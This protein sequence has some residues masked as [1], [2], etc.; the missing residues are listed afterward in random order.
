M[1]ILFENNLYI[2]NIIFICAILSGITISLFVA[3]SYGIAKKVILVY[4]L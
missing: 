3:G 4:S 2:A 1:T